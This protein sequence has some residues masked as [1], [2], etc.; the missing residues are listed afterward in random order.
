VIFGQNKVLNFTKLIHALC[1]LQKIKFNQAGNITFTYHGFVTLLCK[2]Q[3]TP[4]STVALVAQCK[5]IKSHL[6]PSVQHFLFS[7]WL[8]A[9]QMVFCLAQQKW[10]GYKTCFSTHCMSICKTKLVM[11]T[12]TLSI[13]Q[14]VTWR[15]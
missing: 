8:P 6:V 9:K 4:L 13:S 15:H 14:L 11:K 10:K 1:M 2:C 3:K 12:N 5:L 7:V